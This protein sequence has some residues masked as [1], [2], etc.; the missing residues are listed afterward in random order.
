[1]EFYQAE[2]DVAELKKKHLQKPYAKQSITRKL[3]D[4]RLKT[5]SRSLKEINIESTILPITNS[6]EGN[7]LIAL[8]QHQQK[9]VKYRKPRDDVIILHSKT[10][11]HFIE[12]L[13]EIQQQIHE[14]PMNIEQPIPVTN[15]DEALTNLFPRASTIDVKNNW[16]IVAID[17]WDI[18]SVQSSYRRTLSELVATQMKNLFSTMVQCAGCVENALSQKRHDCLKTTEEIVDEN[19]YQ[20]FD[21]VDME[22]ANESCFKRVGRKTLLPIND[23]KCYLDRET[24]YNDEDWLKTT[25]RNLLKLLTHDNLPSC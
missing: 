3:V 5:W 25:K 17:E 8:R 6:K 4:T 23:N 15:F 16:N 2:Q 1:M 22:E 9:D 10:L 24:L 18:N 12:N 20:I 19:F 13:Q 21:A 11:P 7:A 14:K